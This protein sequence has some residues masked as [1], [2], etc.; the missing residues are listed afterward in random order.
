METIPENDFN[1]L[2]AGALYLVSKF[3]GVAIL[4][5]LAKREFFKVPFGSIRDTI[6]STYAKIRFN[7]D[8]NQS[9]EVSGA[10]VVCTK[11]F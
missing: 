2:G 7:K 1:I 10:V 6:L 5:K 4:F 11:C 3:R 8:D 9:I